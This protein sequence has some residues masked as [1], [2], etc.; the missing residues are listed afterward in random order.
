MTDAQARRVHWF[1]RPGALDAEHPGLLNPVYE[2]LDFPVAMGR[3]EDIFL[4]AENARGD[5][6]ELTF[7]D[8]L[9]RVA[10][11]AGVLKLM[12]VGDGAQ[13]SIAPEV[14]ALP[15]ELIRMG[16]FRLGGQVVPAGSGHAPAVTVTA[17]EVPETSAAQRGAH[18]AF[19]KPV[20]ALESHFEGT[21][22]R[23][24][25]QDFTLD[26][27]VRD[28]RIEPAAVAEVRADAILHVQ[29]DGTRLSALE[30]I[31]QMRG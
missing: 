27:V 18:Q 23:V 25:G 30:L 6:V 28:A 4:T 14:A 11:I 13:V 1:T 19:S 3:A 9:D 17:T 21:S 24:D 10:K 15:A 5:A 2:L 29:A 22:A 7:E 12:G 26:V 16:A 20:R 8:A 31:N